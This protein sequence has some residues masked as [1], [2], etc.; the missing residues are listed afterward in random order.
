[1]RR[2]LVLAR[3]AANQAYHNPP[4]G[5][6][7]VKDQKII[8]QGRHNGPDTAH[9]EALALML[10]GEAARGAELYVTLEPCNHYG[11]TAPCVEAIL[12]SGV[13]RVVVGRVDV[14]PH[15]TGGG[16]A[17]LREAG[18]EVE[19]GVCAELARRLLQPWETWVAFKVPFVT[20]KLAVS[21][22]GKIAFE[23]NQPRWLSGPIARAQVQRLRAA[24]DA[25]LVGSA[26]VRADD[27]QL[28][29]RSSRGKNP[30]KVVIASSGGVAAAAKIFQ[31]E[32]PL[33]VGSANMT[34]LQQE[35]LAAAGAEVLCQAQP[36][37]VDLAQALTE[38]G[39]RNIVSVLC[40][41][42]ASLAQSLVS[43]RLANRLMLYQTPTEVG[44]GG[45]ALGEVFAGKN[46]PVG[47]REAVRQRVG[48]DVLVVY[49][50]C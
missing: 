30:L 28:T 9:A 7:V 24:C 47:Y 23:N 12:D 26:T 13:R 4:V 18:V 22:D 43:L 50:L 49:E 40:E 32:P 45:V 44:P 48:R 21:T 2:A 36:G 35:S 46:G 42:G 34:T 33:I 41:G 6:V 17:R 19:T 25:I 1:M 14:N 15:V 8:S 31:Y 39:R 29:N 3:S 11:R 37:K 10:A 38:L 16:I 20:L 5:A 27:P